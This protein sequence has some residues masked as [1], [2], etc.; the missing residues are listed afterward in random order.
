MA[1]IWFYIINETKEWIPPLDFLW[2]WEKQGAFFDKDDTSAFTKEA[3]QFL[4]NYE[5]DRQATAKM[6]EDFKAADL[7]E[8]KVMNFRGN[9]PDGLGSE[10]PQ[11]HQTDTGKKGQ[12]IKEAP[13]SCQVAQ[14][15]Q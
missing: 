2:G 15:R 5:R 9:N 3:F 14:I 8:S 10:R 1:C 7:F 11:N 4:Q 12:G 6:I 13:Q